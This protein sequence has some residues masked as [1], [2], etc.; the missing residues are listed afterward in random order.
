MVDNYNEILYD[1][2]TLEC[3]R[4]ILR[5]FRKEDAGDVFEY[6]GD[7]ECTKYLVWNGCK[8]KEEALGNIVNYYWSRNGIYAIELKEN[9]KCIGCI[10]LRVDADNDK[11]N[12]GYVLNRQYWG[13]GYM[14]EALSALL[15]LCFGKLYL[16]RVEATH[17]IGNEGSGM[18]MKKCGMK[19]EGVKIQEIKVKGIF[20][21][22]AHYGITKKMWLDAHVK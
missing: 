4:I 13:R 12:F 21:D 16:N 9:N 14:T 20:R 17:F 6:G 11:A 10:D 19:L 5:K 22:Q 18:V 8:S 7:E 15:R 3:E 2:E 1:N